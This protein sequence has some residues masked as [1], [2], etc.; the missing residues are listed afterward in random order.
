MLG[1]YVQK[2]HVLVYPFWE[3]Y[4]DHNFEYKPRELGYSNSGIDYR[5]AYRASEGIL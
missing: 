3:G 1:S 4:A 5:G 2:G